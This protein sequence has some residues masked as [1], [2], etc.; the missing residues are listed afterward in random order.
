MVGATGIEPV[1]PT[2]SIVTDSKAETDMDQNTAEIKD[3]TAD[4]T[5]IVNSDIETGIMSRLF[6]VI[7]LKQSPSKFR[8]IFCLGGRGIGPPG[9]IGTTVATDC[10]WGYHVNS[11]RR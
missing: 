10:S 1:T 9:R 5:F 11:G 8:E 7:L 4:V 3:E 2:M 6:R